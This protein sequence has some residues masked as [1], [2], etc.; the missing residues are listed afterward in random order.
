MDPWQE[1][2]DG[3]LL[4]DKLAQVLRRMLVLPRW[5]AEVL[6]LWIVHT[7][8]FLWRN[9]TTCIG[10][11]SPEKQYGKATLRVLSYLVNRAEIAAKISPP[12]FFRVIEE[13]HPTLLIDE[14]GTFLKRNAEL[15][16]ILNTGYTLETA[17]VAP[18]GNQEKGNRSPRGRFSCFCPKAIAFIGQLPEALADRCIVIRMQRKT[19]KERC[20]R[21]NTREANQLKRKCARFVLDHAEAIARARPRMPAEL[22][23]RA[24]DIFEPLTVLAHLAG[25]KW[26]EIARQAGVELTQSAKAAIPGENVR[27]HPLK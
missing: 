25:G 11:E 22:A 14:G 19:A 13:T 8:A 2:V 27:A 15:R 23:D 4:L 20:E 16:R 26:P 24:R 10:I 1:P 7:Y 21:L 17:Y 5:G 12:A 18:M 3:K 6:A 9:V